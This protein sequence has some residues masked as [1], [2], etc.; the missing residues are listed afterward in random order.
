MTHINKIVSDMNAN[1]AFA[2]ATKSAIAKAA[3][4][5]KA[6]GIKAEAKR[7]SAAVEANNWADREGKARPTPERLRKG[8]FVLRDGEDAGVTFAVD[9]SVTELDRLRKSGIITPDQSQGGH[10][11]AALMDRTRLTSPGRSCLNFDPVGYDGDAA[12]SHTAERD[13][14]ERAEIYMAC[15]V[16][17]FAE[18][19]RVCCDHHAPSNIIMLRRGLDT[20]AKFWGGVDVGK[21]MR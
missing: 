16:A 8:D 17:A 5:A 13:T 1:G 6:D 20:C 4:K 9:Q 19:R 3:R 15:G 14:R 21:K 12:P 10:D 7:Q 18:L 11:F 2:K